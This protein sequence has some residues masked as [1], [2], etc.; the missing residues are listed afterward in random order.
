ME[1]LPSTIVDEAAR[2]FDDVNIAD[3]DPE[4]HADF[5][6]ARVLDR[7]TMPSVSALL[8]AYG[9]QRIRSFFCEGGARQVSRRTQALWKV[10]LRL[11]EEE[12]IPKS[13]QQSRSPFWND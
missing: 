10:V 4:A 13:S 7:G 3:I 9:R 1:T 2:L 12:C 11:T 6:I 8:A 5:I